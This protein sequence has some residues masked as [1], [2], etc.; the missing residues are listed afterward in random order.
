M[1]A[2]LKVTFSAATIAVVWLWESGDCLLG[3]IAVPMLLTMWYATRLRAR[4]RAR[5]SGSA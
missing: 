3:I 1:I 2:L 4:R 5:G